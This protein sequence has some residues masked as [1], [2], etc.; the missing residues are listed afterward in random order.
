M[1]IKIL[2]YADNAILMAKGEDDL[3][4]QLYKFQTTAEHYIM[5]MFV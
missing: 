3:Q 4:R 5:L 1:A 2:C